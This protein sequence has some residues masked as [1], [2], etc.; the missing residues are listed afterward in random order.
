MKTLKLFAGSGEYNAEEFIIK[1]KRTK[2]KEGYLRFEST[3]FSGTMDS[4]EFWDRLALKAKEMQK[5]I[6]L[7]Y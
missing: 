4:Q 2:N 6:R 1:G 3:R 5:Y 7:M